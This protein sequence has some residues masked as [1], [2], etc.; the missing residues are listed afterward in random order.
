MARLLNIAADWPAWSR[1]GDPS[2]SSVTARLDGAIPHRI[3]VSRTRQSGS[4]GRDIQH[5]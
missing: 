1:C 2:K 3:R 4:V 5:L